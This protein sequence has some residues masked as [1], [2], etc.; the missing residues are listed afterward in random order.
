VKIAD[1]RA[2]LSAIRAVL[3][4]GS[5]VQNVDRENHPAL[6]YF[7]SASL[8][9]PF[10]PTASTA[11]EL[12]VQTRPNASGLTTEDMFDKTTAV[13]G[14]TLETASWNTFR[15]VSKVAF[16]AE[17]LAIAGGMA[18]NPEQLYNYVKWK[19]ADASASDC[20]RFD[21][22][23]TFGPQS[24]AE[25]N[26]R[27]PRGL[28][29]CVGFS[30]NQANGA[31]VANPEGGFVGRR[32]R[33][34]S[35][36]VITLRDGIDPTLA[37]HPFWSN[38]AA[39]DDEVGMSH[40]LLQKI[41]RAANRT[42]FTASTM[43]VM[44]SEAIDAP[45]KVARPEDN[46]STERAHVIMLGERRFEAYESLMSLWRQEAG[47]DGYTT[48]TNGNRMANHRFVKV[49]RLDGVYGDPIIGLSRRHVGTWKFPG[50]FGQQIKIDGEDGADATMI[51]GY[52]WIGSTGININ[53]RQGSF[54]IHRGW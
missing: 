14:G 52:R 27:I 20:E 10:R 45:R 25:V 53:P 22:Y 2:L 21:N 48:L 23:L 9:A 28:L 16:D 6:Q 46:A 37:D 17:E 39:T 31:Y 32:Y 50:M 19:K 11:I 40:A 49:R 47:S 29:Q 54:V 4:K 38:W 42:N 12:K 43:Q 7:L 3:P 18:Q 13:R 1:N 41:S 5:F 30:M 33:L 51:E 35:G 26:E 24:L 36:E 34:M 44:S 15:Q 8:P